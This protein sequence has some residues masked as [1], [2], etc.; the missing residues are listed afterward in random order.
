MLD[1]HAERGF[2]ER[3]CDAV[4]LGFRP[5]R[6][7]FED[8]TVECSTR[9][10]IRPPKGSNSRTGRPFWAVRLGLRRADTEPSTFA[11]E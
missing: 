4:A 3:S 5:E 1:V 11:P 7:N 10:D 2:D 8:M 9:Y 6:W